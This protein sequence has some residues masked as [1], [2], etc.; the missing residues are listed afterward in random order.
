MHAV[1]QNAKPDGCTL[2]PSHLN[3]NVSIH[4][5]MALLFRSHFKIAYVYLD[6]VI[7][8]TQKRPF[9]KCCCHLLYYCFAN[10]ERSHVALGES[11]GTCGF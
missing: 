2:N 3:G 4:A 6:L 1:G 9:W 10:G 11:L 5:R 7:V 8:D